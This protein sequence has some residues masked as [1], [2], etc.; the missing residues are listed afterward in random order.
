[1]RILKLNETDQMRLMVKDMSLY[2]DSFA[3]NYVRHLINGGNYF[4]VYER[5][6]KTV[7]GALTNGR[8]YYYNLYVIDEYRRQGIATEFIKEQIVNGYITMYVSSENIPMLSVLKKNFMTHIRKTITRLDGKTAYL[9]YVRNKYE[10][11]I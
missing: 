7:A 6:G 10:Y 2:S 4:C 9:F 8:G 5:D 11:D 3:S 1:M